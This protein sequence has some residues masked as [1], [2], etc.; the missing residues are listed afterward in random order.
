MLLR[1]DTAAVWGWH[2]TVVAVDIAAAVAVAVAAPVAA[3]AAVPGMLTPTDPHQPHA[4]PP[5]LAVAGPPHC[6]LLLQLRRTPPPAESWGGH[7]VEASHAV[8][9]A[10]EVGVKDGAPLED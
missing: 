9:A 5:V 7:E 8:A 1:T 10:A 2:H 3:A 4:R 6:R